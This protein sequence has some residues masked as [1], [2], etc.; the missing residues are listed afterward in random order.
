M[1]SVSNGEIK[2]LIHK[3]ITYVKTFVQFLLEHM[4]DVWGAGR[5]VKV[6][7]LSLE[8]NRGQGLIYSCIINF[9]HELPAQPAGHEES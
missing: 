2:Y 8:M 5:G 4:F 9:L 7:R 3:Q 6:F 1:H